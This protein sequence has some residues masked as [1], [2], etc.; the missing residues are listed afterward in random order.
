[1]FLLSMLE[2]IP[3]FYVEFLNFF[4]FFFARLE[5]MKSPLYAWIANGEDAWAWCQYKKAMLPL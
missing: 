1:M 2:T 5:M 4:F 3:K